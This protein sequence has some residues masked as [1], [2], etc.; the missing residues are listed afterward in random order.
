MP[1][2]TGLQLALSEALGGLTANIAAAGE[3]R[4][5]DDL[6]SE[7]SAP[8]AELRKAIPK[9]LRAFATARYNK[10]VKA[11]AKPKVPAGLAERIVAAGHLGGVPELA[12]IARETGV[13]IEVVLATTQLIAEALQLDRLSA[14]AQDAAQDMAYWDRLAT[15]RL[16]RD[17]QRQLALATRRAL[18]S[19][20][21]EDWLKSNVDERKQLNE[22]VRTF[23]ATNPAFAQFALA[24]DAVRS[25]MHAADVQI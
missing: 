2:K 7:L 14:S 13:K 10:S 11:L 17:L 15:R 8:V 9:T 12:A 16:I 22:E 21:A 25:F 18:Q 23:T 1:A 5:I 24:A 19:G 4:P 3:T 6:I 20:G